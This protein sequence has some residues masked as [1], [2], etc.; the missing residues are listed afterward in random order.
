MCGTTKFSVWCVESGA[1]SV[2]CKVSLQSEWESSREKPQPWRITRSAS[3]G[4][5][6][7]AAEASKSTVKWWNML[8]SL[9][10]T[11]NPQKP[12]SS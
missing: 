2:I 12:L 10:P 8:P 11:L 9:L 6:Y 1:V 5:R 4:C 3:P 7:V